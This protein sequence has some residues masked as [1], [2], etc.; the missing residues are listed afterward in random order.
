MQVKKEV[1][2]VSGR[3][4]GVPHFIINGQYQLS[5]AQDPSTFVQIF[6][7]V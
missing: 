6:D 4:N 1:A 2:Q 7:K 5:G 3:I